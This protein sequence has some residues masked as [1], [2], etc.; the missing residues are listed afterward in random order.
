MSS[1]SSMNRHVVA[2]RRDEA[3]IKR[4]RPAPQPATPPAPHD[5]ICFAPTISND[6]YPNVIGQVTVRSPWSTS[7][8]T[9]PASPLCG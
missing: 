1:V 4:A 2:M 3:R 7:Y 6:A 9:A 5:H 8:S